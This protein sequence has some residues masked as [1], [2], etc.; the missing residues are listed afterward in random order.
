MLLKNTV[1]LIAVLTLASPYLAA[2]K[3]PPKAKKDAHIV[4]EVDG[5]IRVISQDSAADFKKTLKQNYKD[6]VTSYN[7]AKKQAKKEKRKFTDPKPKKPKTKNHGTFKSKALADEFV[8]KLEAK[9]EKKKSKDK[10]KGKGK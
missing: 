6:A 4:M 10:G 7:E 1:L 3:N 2:Q 5:S 8:T 9:R